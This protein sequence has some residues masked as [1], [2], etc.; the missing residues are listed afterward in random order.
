VVNFR[1][2][3]RFVADASLSHSQNICCCRFAFAQSKHLLLSLRFRTVKTFV[4]VASLSHSQNI[5]C[6]RFAFATE[7]IRCCRCVNTTLSHRKNSLRCKV[8]VQ[9][10]VGHGGVITGCD[11]F[12]LRSSI[13][14]PRGVAQSERESTIYRRFNKSHQQLLVMNHL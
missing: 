12:S 6:C 11:A 13:A 4:A 8:S 7:N 14:D 10:D 5:C 1:S 9:H 3:G 2:E